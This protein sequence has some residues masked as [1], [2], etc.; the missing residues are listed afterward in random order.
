[1]SVGAEYLKNIVSKIESF[2]DDNVYLLIFNFLSKGDTVK[3]YS[4]N[5]NG[6]FFNLNK[7]DSS[8]LEELDNLIESCIVIKKENKKIEEK[9]E[10]D[11]CEMKKTIC[12]LSNKDL[13]NYINERSTLS[14]VLEFEKEEIP[15]FIKENSSDEDEYVEEDFGEDFGEHKAFIKPTIYDDTSDYDERELFGDCTDSD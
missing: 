7:M 3:N 5:S 4:H 9:R 1:M 14:T 2:K 12:S 15:H 8:I 10:A 11:L 13:D 6:I